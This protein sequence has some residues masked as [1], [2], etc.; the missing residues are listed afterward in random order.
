MTTRSLGRVL[1]V[2]CWVGLAV[3][4]FAQPTRTTPA[5][6]R[7]KSFLDAIPAIDTHDHLWPFDRLGRRRAGLKGEA[8]NLYALLGNSY[9]TC[10]NPLAARKPGESFDDG[11]HGQG[12]FRRRPRHE[13]LSLPASGVHRPVRRGFRSC[14]RPAGP[15][16]G[17]Q[18]HREL[19]GSE[20]A[21][22]GDHRAGQHRAD[23]HR[24][25][26]GTA[27]DAARLSVWR[28]V[29]QRQHPGA[30]LS[31]RRVPSRTTT[32]IAFAKD[33]GLQVETLDDYV[34]L[35]DRLVADAKARGL[36]A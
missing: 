17:P 7:M 29:A 21:V 9:Y 22:P 30:R 13:F 32:P 27:G 24:S 16:G 11:G 36:P 31:P 35:L 5:Y 23:V 18:D 4:L 26:L 14:H 34:V 6:E 33:H 20:M 15:R 2:C 19:Q 8:M 10:Y 3:P 25:V 28:P 1:C 12:Q